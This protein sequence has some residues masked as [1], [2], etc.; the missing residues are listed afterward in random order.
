MCV[1]VCVCMGVWL[2]L[3]N[4]SLHH[5]TIYMQFFRHQQTFVVSNW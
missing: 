5:I 2:L 1:C 3:H 4:M